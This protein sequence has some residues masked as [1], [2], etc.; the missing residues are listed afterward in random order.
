MANIKFTKKELDDEIMQII[1]QQ[2]NK[3]AQMQRQRQLPD[4][5]NMLMERAEANRNGGNARNQN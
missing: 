2:G 3:P 5:A 4:I 1:Q